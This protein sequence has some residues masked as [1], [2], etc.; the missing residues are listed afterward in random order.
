MSVKIRPAEVPPLAANVPQAAPSEVA[1]LLRFA[2]GNS[3]DAVDPEATPGFSGSKA[4]GKVAQSLDNAVFSDLQERL[5]ANAAVNGLQHSVLL[6]IQGRDSAG[7][8]GLVKHVV[9]ALSPHGVEVA[10][11]GVP[12]AEEAAHYFLWR[13]YRRLPRWGNIGVFDRSHY[14]DILAVR[15][16]GLAPQKVWEERYDVINEFEEGLHESGI[17]VVK[18]MLTISPDEQEERLRDRLVRADKQW[19]HSASDISD[20]AAWGDYTTAFQDVLDRT[21]RVGAPWFVV[22]AN[23]KWYSRWAVTRILINELQQLGLEWPQGDFDPAAELAR[24]EASR[25]KKS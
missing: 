6:I 9:G 8:G 1:D 19:K 3:F 14:E 12:T 11:F 22:P 5:F 21:S 25:P 4:D 10:A 2:P 15:M 13:V 17:R 7:K 24:L 18:V 16:H 23:R 20:R